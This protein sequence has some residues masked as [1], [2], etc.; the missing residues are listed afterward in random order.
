MKKF[1]IPYIVFSIIFVTLFV[2]KITTK[3]ENNIKYIPPNPTTE[4]PEQQ[5]KTIIEEIQDDDIYYIVRA[6]ENKIFLYDK[7]NNIIEKL[8]IDYNNLR[9][10]DKNLFLNG[11]KVTDMQDVYQ[12]IE[13]FTN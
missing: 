1:Y 12:L 3:D 11:I 10:Y 13:D 9:E 4:K 7:K 5:E 8:N 2:I 6:S